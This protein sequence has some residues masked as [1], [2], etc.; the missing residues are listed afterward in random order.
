MKWILILSIFVSCNAL[1]TLTD[2]ETEVPKEFSEGICQSCETTQ[3][4]LYNDLIAFYNFDGG[5]LGDDKT[6]QNHLTVT[7][8]PGTSTGKNGLALNCNSITNADFLAIQSLGSQFS[9]G[10][11]QNFSISFWFKTASLAAG[12]VVYLKTSIPTTLQFQTVAATGINFYAS[13]ATALNLDGS[14]APVA[15]TWELWTLVVTRNSKVEIYRNGVLDAISN[16]VNT[17]KNFNFSKLA[18]CGTDTGGTA[19]SPADIDSVGIWGRAL[20]S[21]EIMELYN[22]NSGLD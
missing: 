8:T 18:L 1:K 9:F 7:G 13:E 3:S 2:G 22:G 12:R 6:G 17:D 4:T 21:Q 15:N 19:G 5:S 20:S 16:T 14:T 10:T 11:N